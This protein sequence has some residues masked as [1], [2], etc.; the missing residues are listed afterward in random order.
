MGLVNLIRS[1]PFEGM[2][3][4]YYLLLNCVSRPSETQNE[5]AF[6]AIPLRHLRTAFAQSL[7]YC[8]RSLAYRKLYTRNVL[9]H[10]PSICSPTLLRHPRFG[11]GRVTE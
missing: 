5:A 4:S 11:G 8:D 9:F 3:L 6:L 2:K 10:V 1:W 7:P